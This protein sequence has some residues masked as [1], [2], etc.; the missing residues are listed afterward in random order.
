MNLTE[1]I[2]TIEKI[3][4]ANP[5]LFMLESDSVATDNQIHETEQ[6]LSLLLPEEYKQF[7]KTF[8]GG[9]FAFVNI[10]SVSEDSEWNIVEQNY[11]I[12]LVDSHNFLA[13]SDIG[14][15]DFYGFEIINGI[16]SSAIKVYDHDSNQ[17]EATVFETL[18]DYLLRV[19][20]KHG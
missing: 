5:V 4:S 10:F 15:G 7:I 14:T 2:L 3:K 19:G 9:Y 18:F 17:L 1:F 12:G 16:C 11:R 13:V 8:G 20:L 6:S